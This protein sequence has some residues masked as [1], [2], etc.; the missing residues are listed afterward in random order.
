MAHTVKAWITLWKMGHT[1]KMGQIWKTGHTVK[2][3]SHLIIM[4]HCEKQI[5]FGNK[6]VT[7]KNETHLEKMGHTVK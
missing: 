2:T 3:E 4:V 1:G 5:R 6:C 7:L